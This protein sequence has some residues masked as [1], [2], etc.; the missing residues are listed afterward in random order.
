MRCMC[1]IMHVILCIA[2]TI[3]CIRYRKGVF[4]L[5]APHLYLVWGNTTLGTGFKLI[6]IKNKIVVHRFTH[7][8]WCTLGQ[9][10]NCWPT[11]RTVI[12][13]AGWTGWWDLGLGDLRLGDLR[14]GYLL[15]LSRCALELCPQPISL[16]DLISATVAHASRCGVCLCVTGDSEGW[17]ATATASIEMAIPCNWLGTYLAV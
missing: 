11:L 10:K 15:L 6:V 17:Y 8:S 9:Y 3:I 4:I 16:E 12:I 7:N 14:P 2:C 1:T 13:I 5:D